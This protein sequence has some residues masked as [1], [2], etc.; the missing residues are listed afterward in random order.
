[1]WTRLAALVLMMAGP[2]HA[3]AE[4]IGVEYAG[5]AS[6]S[7]PDSSV[8]FTLPRGWVG[9]WGQDS[10]FVVTS[11]EHYGRI[12]LRFAALTLPSAYAAM[13]APITLEGGETLLPASPLRE[14]ATGLVGDYAVRGADAN[15]V[16]RVHASVGDHGVTVIALAE[17][18]AMDSTLDTA[19]QIQRS[20]QFAAQPRP[21]TSGR[22]SLA[23]YGHCWF[24]PGN[25][26]VQDGAL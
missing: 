23:V 24:R 2:A 25:V 16:A 19:A 26:F 13:S 9:S 21:A 4:E 17:F 6:L 5:P 8:S 11:S 7:A 3:A 14:S 12:E 22:H 10:S 1:M 15:M 20:L 18:D